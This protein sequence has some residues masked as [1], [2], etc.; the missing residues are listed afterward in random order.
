MNRWIWMSLFAAGVAAA[1]LVRKRAADG[2]RSRSMAAKR[3][4]SD[5]ALDARLAEEID[6]SFPASDPPSHTPVIG[7]SLAH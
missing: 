6:E 7:P 1:V 4:P 3:S 5:E 2:R